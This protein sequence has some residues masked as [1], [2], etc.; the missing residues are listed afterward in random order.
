MKAAVITS[1]DQPPRY[2]DFPDPT[3]N[4]P[5]EIL[6][7]VLAVGLHHLTRGRAS[8]THYSSTRGLPLVV[9]VDGVGRDADGK[10]RYFAQSPG[11]I[12]TMADKTVIKLD[13][14]I[15]LS[16]ES[17]PVA[18]AGAMNPAMASWLALRCRVP[19]ERGQKVLVLGATGSSGSMA[20]QIAR[21]LGA[22]QVIAVGR[23]EQRLGKLLALGATEIMTLSD[24][25]HGAGA[26]ACEVDCVLDFLWGDSSL[27]VMETV[28]KQ[29]ADRSRPLTWIHVGSMAGEVAAIPGAFLRSANLHIVGSGHGSVSGR[30][31][32]T[33]LP[34]LAKEITRGTFR[35]DVKAVP[36]RNVEQVWCEASRSGER[37]VITPQQ[38]AIDATEN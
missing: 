34:A 29:R 7:E 17:D 23:D 5:G 16:S 25:Q 20:V 27:R 2:S 13:H 11:Q 31:I 18:I 14:S 10:L 38:P 6:V 30:D 32:L 9:G 36:L 35:I 28:L 26:V 4:G 37:I 3:P 15:E 22:S 19:F 21:H 12:G 24:A 33:E 8:G 1:S